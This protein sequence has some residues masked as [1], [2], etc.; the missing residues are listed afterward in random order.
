VISTP[1]AGSKLSIVREG[2]DEILRV[3]HSPKGVMPFFIAAF[4]VFWLGGWVMGFKSATTQLMS[5]PDNLFL[6][7]W[8]AGWTLGGA[9]AIVFLYRILRPSVA[10]SFMLRAGGV[11]HDSGI[12][13]FKMSFTYANQKDIWNS[14]FQKRRI[15]ELTFADL[16]TLKLRETENGNRLTIDKGNERLEL[17]VAATEIEREWVHAY[18][19]KRYS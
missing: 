5:K 4:M 10:E 17:A 3:P 7:F 15:R 8:L 16:R 11:I 14:V 2:V 19:S 13:P 6:V 18:L 12:P 9:F 1:P